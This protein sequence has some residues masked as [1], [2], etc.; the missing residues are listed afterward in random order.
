M[1]NIEDVFEFV[2]AHNL[3]LDEMCFDFFFIDDF[4]TFLNDYFT[5]MDE[6]YERVNVIM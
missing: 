3:C 2:N 6:L 5:R 4:M 1:R